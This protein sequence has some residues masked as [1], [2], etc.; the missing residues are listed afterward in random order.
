MV[1]GCCL[2]LLICKN[3]DDD[4]DDDEGQ[5]DEEKKTF[6]QEARATAWLVCGRH[7]RDYFSLTR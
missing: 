1:C 5:G 6:G 2:C 7:E 3:D 4:D